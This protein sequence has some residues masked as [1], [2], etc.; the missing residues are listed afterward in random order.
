LRALSPFKNDHADW[1]QQ[2]SIISSH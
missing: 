2:Q 1:L